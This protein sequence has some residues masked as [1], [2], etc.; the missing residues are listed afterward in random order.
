PQLGE[1]HGRAC[2]LAHAAQ[3]PHGARVAEEH[4][5]PRPAAAPLHAELGGCLPLY[6]EPDPLVEGPGDHPRPP[7]AVRAPRSAPLPDAARLVGRLYLYLRP[8]A[9][10]HARGCGH[11]DVARHS[12]VGGNPAWI[13]AYAG[14]T[15]SK[16]LARP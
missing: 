14:M 16:P 2:G 4:L 7:R 9:E 8:A 15:L 5:R 10:R 13:L 6:G 11:T 3:L 12:R 1:V